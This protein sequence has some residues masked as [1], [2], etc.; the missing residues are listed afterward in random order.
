MFDKGNPF[1]EY[2]DVIFKI[3]RN[4]SSGEPQYIIASK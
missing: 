4:S 1:E 3:K 2:V